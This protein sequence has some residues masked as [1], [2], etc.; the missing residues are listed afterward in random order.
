MFRLTIASQA[1]LLV[2]LG[3]VPLIVPAGDILPTITENPNEVAHKV[4]TLR[5]LG[6]LY[7]T[8]SAN[9]AKVITAGMQDTLGVWTWEHGDPI[10]HALSMPAVSGI[11]RANIAIAV[12]PAVTQQQGTTIYELK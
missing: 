8:F 3:S 9:S 7:V 1:L 10:N 12:S 5:E 6:A 2:I 11:S 4:A